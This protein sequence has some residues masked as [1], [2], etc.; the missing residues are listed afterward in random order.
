[1]DHTTT[2]L[3]GAAEDLKKCYENVVHE[4]NLHQSVPSMTSA[5]YD[6]LRQ[7]FAGRSGLKEIAMLYLLQLSLNA[8]PGQGGND[9]LSYFRVCMYKQSPFRHGNCS[10]I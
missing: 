3:Q 9:V 7:V 1:M 5:H 6:S 2:K 10:H 8:D 4:D